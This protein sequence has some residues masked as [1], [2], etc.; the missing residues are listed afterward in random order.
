MHILKWMS[1]TTFE[2]LDFSEAV[3]KI[4]ETS[5]LIALCVPLRCLFGRGRA[6]FICVHLRLSADAFGFKTI[7]KNLDAMY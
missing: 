1:A 6:H 3:L 2:E 5:S 7:S 4:I